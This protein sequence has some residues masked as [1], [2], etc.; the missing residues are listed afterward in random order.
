MHQRRLAIVAMWFL[1]LC[2]AMVCH[3]ENGTCKRT[4]FLTISPLG[5]KSVAIHLLVFVQTHL[6]IYTFFDPRTLRWSVV[7]D[8]FGFTIGFICKKEFIYTEELVF[9]VI[10][11]GCCNF[12]SFTHIDGRAEVDEYFKCI[13]RVTDATH[14]SNWLVNVRRPDYE[15]ICVSPLT[16]FLIAFGPPNAFLIWISCLASI[17]TF[18][19][20]FISVVGAS[21]FSIVE[22]E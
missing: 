10:L 1:S 21:T 18:I 12:D 2:S 22:A 17:C 13:D 15:F 9:Q 16:H 11:V 7:C 5:N 14:I 20:S 19:Y 3:V 6:G 8:S 4:E